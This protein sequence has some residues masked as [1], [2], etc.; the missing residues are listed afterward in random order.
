MTRDLTYCK[1]LLQMVSKFGQENGYDLLRMSKWLIPL[2]LPVKPT[3]SHDLNPGGYPAPKA[4]PV[5]S[6]VGVQDHVYSYTCRQCN[7]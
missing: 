3:G 6:A 2:L 4:V 7:I 5:M 1:V